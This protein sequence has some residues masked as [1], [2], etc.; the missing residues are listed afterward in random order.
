MIGSISL[1]RR[2]WWKS[3]R[4]MLSMMKKWRKWR[5]L[6]FNVQLFTAKTQPKAHQMR[7]ARRY[8]KVSFIYSIPKKYFMRSR[9]REKSRRQERPQK[10][11][12]NLTH[13]LLT[14]TRIIITRIL[15]LSQDLNFQNQSKALL[16]FLCHLKL[17]WKRLSWSW[18]LKKD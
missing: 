12:L 5:K 2:Y 17:L 15:I 4:S 18:M 1:A 14:R 11:K 6:I 9:K 7:L 8:S 10:I 13:N 16:N 3:R